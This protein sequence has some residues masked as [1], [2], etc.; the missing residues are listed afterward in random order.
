MN[1]PGAAFPKLTPE[2]R[3]LA[4]LSITYQDEF[5]HSICDGLI[6]QVNLKQLDKMINRAR[7]WPVIYQNIK[8]HYSFIIIYFCNLLSK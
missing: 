5:P 1:N 2:L 4:L 6:E 7:T 3:L 8:L